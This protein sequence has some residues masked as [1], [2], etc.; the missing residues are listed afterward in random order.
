[1]GAGFCNFSHLDWNTQTPFPPSSLQPQRTLFSRKVGRE[2]EGV[3]STRPE[4]V[5]LTEC[6]E[7]HGDDVSLVYLTNSEAIL[8]TSHRWIG[9]GTKL[10]LSKSPDADV[11]KKI[12]IK[13][14]KRVLAGAAT[15]VVKV[16]DH[17]GDPLNEVADIRTEMGHRK[18]Q[19][20][21][22]WNNPTNRTIYRWKIGQHT[23][24]NAWTNTVRAGQF[25]LQVTGTYVRERVET[26]WGSV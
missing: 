20:E 23:R 13:L 16:N 22:G 3:S 9:C 25:P 15:L 19:K 11:L 18:E 17:R 1:M 10:N 7:D 21:V 26:R 6:L 8:Q 2:D 5:A 12:I 14:Q 24:S 4:L